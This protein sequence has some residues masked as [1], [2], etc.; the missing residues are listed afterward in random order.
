MTQVHC[1]FDVVYFR[2]DLPS[3]KIVHHKT[4][5]NFVRLII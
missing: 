5:R 1:W 2:K 3:E 4:K